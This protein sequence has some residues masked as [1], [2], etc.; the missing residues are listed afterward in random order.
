VTTPFRNLL[1]N[2]GIAKANGSEEFP[3][4]FDD[5]DRDILRRVIDRKLSK[6]RYE[7]LVAT[8]MAC[9]HVASAAIEGDFV[10]C[11]V[12][13]GGNALIAADVFS[14][15]CKPAKI[16]L[17]DTFAGM[18]APGPEDVEATSGKSAVSR[19]LRSKQDTHN[20]WC[21][22]P[23]EEVQE[24]FREAGLLSDYVRM[25][26]GDVLATLDNEDNL[27]KRVSVLR[28]DTNWYESTRKELE[29]FWPRL[30]QGGILMIDDYGH[31]SGARKAVDEFFSGPA[32]PFFHYIDYTGRLVIKT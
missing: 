2:I 1:T 21:Y 6:A 3:V 19:Y 20:K 29:V 12:W 25:I 17:Y 24:I 32:R 27:P 18:T 26:K 8:L 15:L 14:R 9:R 5:D 16:F 11:G 10:E 7:R 31:W 4:E 13:R 30:A 23:L 28:L 22:S